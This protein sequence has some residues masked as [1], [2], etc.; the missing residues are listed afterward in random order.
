MN[1]R[2]NLEEYLV[3]QLLAGAAGND[4]RTTRLIVRA[5]SHVAEM[6][7]RNGQAFVLPYCVCGPGDLVEIVREWDDAR[8]DSEPGLWELDGFEVAETIVPSPRGDA[9]WL[10]TLVDIWALIAARTRDADLTITEDELTIGIEAIC[11]TLRAADPSLINLPAV[12]LEAVI[13]DWV[14]DNLAQVGEAVEFPSIDW[15]KLPG[16][17]RQYRFADGTRA[18]LI[19]RTTEPHRDLPPGT[20]IVIELKAGRGVAADIDQLAGY[21]ERVER[22]LADPDDAVLGVLI[23][24]GLDN[25]VAP[26]IRE[27]DLAIFAQTLTAC[28]YHEYVYQQLIR[29]ETGRF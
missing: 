24:D 7:M 6:C 20:W 25:G 26:R 19:C 16:R 13:E 8:D 10:V 28:G 11:R 4:E 29:A 1:N 5:F 2:I 17:G 23:A 22:E 21:V 18:D 3:G 12:T 14:V 9:H 15:P 27:L